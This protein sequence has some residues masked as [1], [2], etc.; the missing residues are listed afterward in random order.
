MRFVILAIIIV[1][2]VATIGIEVYA[3]QKES[4]RKPIFAT[5]TTMYQRTGSSTYMV[6]TSS[7]LSSGTKTYMNTQFG[8]I[9]FRYPGD[10]SLREERHTIEEA[11]QYR[12]PLLSAI[13]KRV[14]S[15][16]L[17]QGTHEYAEVI[18]FNLYNLPES[19]FHNQSKQIIGNIEW[20]ISI[21]TGSEYFMEART[22]RGNYTYVFQLHSSKPQWLS[23][24]APT[25]NVFEKLLSTASLQ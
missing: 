25:A 8:F 19:Y 23:S 21:Q 22:S 9:K 15:Y 20:S 18:V 13:L 5:A 17:D 1:T 14:G 3:F 4:V 2:V 10:F 11:T 12:V 16:R 7:T 6:G 24:E